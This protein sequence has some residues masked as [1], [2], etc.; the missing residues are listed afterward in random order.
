L[1]GA[2]A[3]KHGRGS[4]IRLNFGRSQPF[5]VYIMISLVS[6][7]CAELKCDDHSLSLYIRDYREYVLGLLR[8]T[9]LYIA[10]PE[11]GENGG[12]VVA[13]GFVAGCGQAATASKPPTGYT[14]TPFCGLTRSSAKCLLARGGQ[15]D[16]TVS[17]Y[18]SVVTGESLQYPGLPCIIER[19][20]VFGGELYTPLEVVK[21]DVAKK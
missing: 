2:R 12:E 4:A 3:V 17:Q 16:V 6:F 10:V 13:S 8:K 15:D 19:R 18:Y 21:V 14:P 11:Y 20:G 7:L 1:R 5:H 9:P